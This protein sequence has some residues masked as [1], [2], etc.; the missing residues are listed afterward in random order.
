MVKIEGCEYRTLEEEIITLLGLYGEVTSE[1]VE[2]CFWDETA[3]TTTGKNRSGKYLVMMRLNCDIPHYPPSP[4]NVCEMNKDVPCWHQQT[5][6]PILWAA[7]KKQFCPSNVKVSWTDYIKN[8]IDSNPDIPVGFFG[9]WKE[10]IKKVNTEKR[11]T[12][13]PQLQTL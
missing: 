1:L 9:K 6:H 13:S 5:L 4:T 10:I 7:Q 3:T 2:D 8:F 11:E 12:D